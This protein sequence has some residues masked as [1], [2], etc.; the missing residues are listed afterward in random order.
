[1]TDLLESLFA[2]DEYDD[3]E[4]IV[5]PDV[6][7]SYRDLKRAINRYG[8]A[9]G[10]LGVGAGERVVYLTR[11]TP[12]FVAAFF[13]TVKIGAAA[14]VVS[15]RTPL[16]DLSYLV[17]QC[18][19]RLLVFDSGSRELAHAALARG[20]G[21]LA[22]TCLDGAHDGRPGL[23]TLTRTAADVLASAPAEP[24]RE[25]FWVCSSGSTGRPKGVVHTRRAL[26]P[27]CTYFHRETLALVPGDRVFCSSKLSF[28]YALGNG[29]LAPLS[30]GLT[31]LLDPDWPTVESA[32]ETVARRRPTAVF[33]TPSLYRAILHQAVAEDW[34]ALGRVRR[35]VSAGEHL[36]PSL[37]SA[38]RRHSGR[39]IANCYGCSETIFLAF[40]A[41]ADTATPGSV[42]T[43]VPGVETRLEAPTQT[44]GGRR[45][46]RLHLRHPFMTSGYGLLEEETAR[47]FQDGWFATGD[48]FEID[49]S[50]CWHHRG[51][52]D[53]LVKIAGQ[54]VHVREVEDAV[55]AEAA[56]VEAA[57]VTAHDR[58]GL[59]RIALF[60]VPA[61]G[62]APQTVVESVRA[63]LEHRLPTYKR[64]RWIRSAPGLP[65][66][67]TGKVQRHRLRQLIEAETR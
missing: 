4:A 47:R 60:L 51:R 5:S 43:P 48:L 35:F 28:A 11:D 64:P 25:A 17:E 36:P 59:L 42:G 16:D 22:G 50:G 12:E 62:R 19:P 57:A 23:D 6:T 8:H 2:G 45:S 61:A 10:D 13:A 32:L 30:L 14:V 63:A 56:V 24:R 53:D 26:H 27:A 66:T 15:T 44:A 40:T 52:E 67:T 49:A 7:W 9:L 33:S 37:V 65:R 31:L 21:A 34:S 54:W 39:A 18:A 1:M 58:D 29:L 41:D 38:W 46:G 20:H 3:L 55:S